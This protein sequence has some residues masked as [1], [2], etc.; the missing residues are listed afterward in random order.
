MAWKV[1]EEFDADSPDGA[2]ASDLIVLLDEVNR[3]RE[4]LRLQQ[5]ASGSEPS[6]A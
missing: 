6:A 4:Q 1:V 3:L 5:A 2:I